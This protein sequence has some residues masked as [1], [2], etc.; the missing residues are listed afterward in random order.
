MLRNAQL[1]HFAI[2]ASFALLFAALAGC[3]TPLIPAAEATGDELE[4]P[5]EVLKAHEAALDFLHEGAYGITPS[6]VVDWQSSIGGENMPEGFGI[7]FFTVDSSI[8][9]VT[10]GLP[11]TEDTLYHVSYG[12]S[13]IGF[14]WQAM[15]DARG[16]IVYTGRDAELGA[17]L[18]NASYVYCTDQGYQ[19]DVQAQTPG[20]LCGTCIF[21]DGSACNGWAFLRGQ[22]APGDRP[23]A[24][25]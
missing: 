19:Y 22:C 17:T 6:P 8:M 15:V 10:Y 12:D 14:C 2:A 7:Y 21:P 25:R 11:A 3:S 5:P 18:E 16:K 13:V 24:S 20:G 9:T 4:I 23:A 1:R